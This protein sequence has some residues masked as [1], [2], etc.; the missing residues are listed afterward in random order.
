M[1]SSEG[2]L[3]DILQKMSC[4]EPCG[5]KISCEGESC[6]YVMVSGDL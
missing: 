2:D 4:D 3:I 6:G 5:Q 1:E